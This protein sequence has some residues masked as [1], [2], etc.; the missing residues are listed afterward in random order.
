MGQNKSASIHVATRTVGTV[1]PEDIR[2]PV[3]NHSRK[4]AVSF[5]VVVRRDQTGLVST[6]KIDQHKAK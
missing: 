4:K 3:L 6:A 2:A 5:W 1:F